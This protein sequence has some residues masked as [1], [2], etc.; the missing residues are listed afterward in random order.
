MRANCGWR[1]A[2][3]DHLNMSINLPIITRGM[4]D[5]TEELHT[6]KPTASPTQ[7]PTGEWMF[8][9]YVHIYMYLCVCMP[10]CVYVFVLMCVCVQ[11]ITH[12]HTYIYMYMHTSRLPYKFRN[13]IFGWVGLGWV[14]SLERNG[15]SC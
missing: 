13:S 14:G 11:C 2:L 8:I 1:G 4:F 5:C 7:S 3:F 12:T 10:L 9:L 6:L 15:G